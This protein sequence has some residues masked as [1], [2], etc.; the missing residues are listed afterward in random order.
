MDLSSLF[1]NRLID[2]LIAYDLHTYDQ[3]FGF[4][5]KLNFIP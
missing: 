3:C 2:E 4:L 1:K 5:Q